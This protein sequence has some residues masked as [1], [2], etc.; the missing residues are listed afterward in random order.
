V[1]RFTLAPGSVDLFI[2]DPATVGDSRISAS[3]TPAEQEQAKRFRFEKDARHWRA[4]RTAL[5]EILGEALSIDPAAI[6]LEFGEFGKPLLPPPRADL[7]FNLSHCHNLALIALC[8][9]GPVGVDIEP[10]NRGKSLLGCEDAFC[11]P[12]EIKGLPEQLV[13]RSILLL[14]YWTAKESI[15]K[16]LG[17]G[18]SLAPQ[19]VSI[20]SFIQTG[21]SDPNDPRFAGIRVHCLDHR[22]LDDHVAWLAVPETT[23]RVQFHEWIP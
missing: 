12:D 18:L 16:A 7:H 9:E 6:T 5:R 19:S 4:C 20:N 3:L 22:S 21:F 17:T 13:M 23:S 2:V 15:L 14:R 11:H 10:A 1:P 8:R